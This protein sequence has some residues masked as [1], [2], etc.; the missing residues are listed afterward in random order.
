MLTITWWLTSF[1]RINSS[2]NPEELPEV[3][4][5]DPDA[6]KNHS[7]TENKSYHTDIL[8]KIKQ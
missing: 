1:K 2:G 6:W 5:Q 3:L 4:K 8:K 7:D